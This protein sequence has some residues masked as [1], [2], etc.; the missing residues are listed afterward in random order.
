LKKSWEPLLLVRNKRCVT[1]NSYGD[2][3]FRHARLFVSESRCT[4]EKISQM[5]GHWE[6]QIW[7]SSGNFFVHPVQTLRPFNDKYP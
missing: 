7:L 2:A 6:G 3:L 5:H 4:Q 1:F